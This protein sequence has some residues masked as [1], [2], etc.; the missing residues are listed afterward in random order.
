MDIN[1]SDLVLQTYKGKHKVTQ[2]AIYQKQTKNNPVGK[3]VCHKKTEILSRT[4]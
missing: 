1:Q 3:N 4:P 2:W